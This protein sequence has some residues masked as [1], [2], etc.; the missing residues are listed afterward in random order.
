MTD[1]AYRQTYKLPH[2]YEI[3]LSLNGSNL[4]CAWSPSPPRG[5]KAR[6]V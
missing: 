5:R 4:Q 3:E 1:F 6:A 2:G